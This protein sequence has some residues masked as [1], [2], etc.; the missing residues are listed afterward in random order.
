MARLVYS[1]CVRDDMDRL[2]DF[3]AHEDPVWAVDAMTVILDGL[4]L[5]KT[6]PLIGR[7]VEF[8]TRELVI[9]KGKT[10][11]L[12]LYDYDEFNDV[13]LVLAIRHQRESGYN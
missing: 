6:H 5:L 3:L 10:G 9:S 8:S 1:G 7:P 13:A 11:Y 4:E 12:A 2:F